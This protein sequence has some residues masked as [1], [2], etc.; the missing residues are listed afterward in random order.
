L[1]QHDLPGTNMLTIAEC[2]DFCGLTEEEVLAI[3]E[4]E[5]LD[6]MAAI[7]MAGYLTETADGERRIGRMIL[8]DIAAAQA[9][10]DAAHSALLKRALA[11][12]VAAH[13]AARTE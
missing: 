4:H 7:A 8:D 13:P 9:R 2:L 10:G 11:H 6:E 3:A 5:N 1:L 12:F